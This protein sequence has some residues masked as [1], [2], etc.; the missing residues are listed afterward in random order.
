MAAASTLAASELHARNRSWLEA[1][2]ASPDASTQL[3]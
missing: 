3:L 1:M 2:A